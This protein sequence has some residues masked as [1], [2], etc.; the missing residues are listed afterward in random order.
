MSLCLF[1][2]RDSFPPPF[3]FL[4]PFISGEYAHACIHAH[5]VLL[6]LLGRSMLFCTSCTFCASNLNIKSNTSIGQ[7]RAVIRVIAVNRR[8]K[9]VH[10][11]FWNYWDPVYHSTGDGPGYLGVVCI[12]EPSYIFRTDTHQGESNFVAMFVPKYF[13]WNIVAGWSSIL[14]KMECNVIIWFGAVVWWKK[15]MFCVYVMFAFCAE[16]ITSWPA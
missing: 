5:F 6:V 3:F 11:Y 12:Q 16:N 13:H 8:P 1:Q 2:L 4:P 10:G 14:M 7:L 9:C 15:Y